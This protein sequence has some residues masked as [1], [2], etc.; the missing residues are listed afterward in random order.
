MSASALDAAGSAPVA[1]A[2]AAEEKSRA[3]AAMEA[4]YGAAPGKEAA[5]DG[6]EFYEDDEDDEEDDDEPWTLFSDFIDENGAAGVRRPANGGAAG[7]GVLGKAGAA[8]LG[9]LGGGGG[10]GGAAAKEFGASASRVQVGDF[11]S[12]NVGSAVST[13]ARESEKK[14]DKDRVR[15][16]DKADRATSEQVLD[17]RTRQM[18]DK[19]V[20]NG[21]LRA[22]HG[23]ISTGKE[24][25]V[26]YAESAEGDRA[27]K[28]Y[29]TSILVFKDRDKYVTGEYR[30]RH[31]YCKSNPR[32]MVK[33]WAEKE[34][35]NL[36]RLY[37]EGLPC[38]LPVALKNHVLIMSFIG[39]AEG[40]AAPRL[41]NAELNARQ[42]RDAYAQ[43]VRLMRRM[44][45]RCRLVHADLSEYN[46]LY[47]DGL[48]YVIDVSQSVEHDHPHA[49]DFLKKDAENMTRFFATAGGHSSAVAT[50]SVQE[51]FEFVTRDDLADDDATIDAYLADMARKVEARARSGAAEPTAA[52]QV[53]AAV[54]LGAPVLRRLDEIDDYEKEFAL[55]KKAGAVESFRA[56]AIHNLAIHGSANQTKQQQQV[57]KEEAKAAAPVPKPAKA[58]AP[59]VAAKATAAA[60]AAPAAAPAASKA[61][62]AHAHAAKPSAKAVVAP[63]TLAAARDQDLFAGLLLPQA[64]DQDTLTNAAS[65]LPEPGY[66]SDGAEDEDEEDEDDEEEDDLPANA[67]HTLAK[68]RRVMT[69]VTFGDDDEDDSDEDDDDD[70]EDDDEDDESDSGD[71]G[72]SDHEDG[73]GAAHGPGTPGW[74]ERPV[75][76]AEQL[77]AERKAQKK[78]A[79]EAQA[80][81]RKT[82]M[83]KKDKKKKLKSKK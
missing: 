9:G 7:P 6:E 29:K 46:L 75:L 73:E 59:A 21:T 54:F 81:K 63:P 42:M 76:T 38:P 61:H 23:C 15:H 40:Q 49:M 41:K 79:K 69:H 83:K 19:L 52:E 3:Q 57:P 30:F 80:E 62:A 24:A 34:M 16:K 31:G 13:S 37:S 67:N 45:H 68:S 36:K 51:L 64:G 25:N 65:T 11:S 2:P 66:V 12:R 47:F 39:S 72:K 18:L 70:D 10:G 82:K 35:R 71:E 22:I 77:R 60:A 14:L 33:V 26:Y 44:Y 50:M 27:V 5:A 58:V 28:I 1:A 55:Q 4:T 20:S 78:Q 48:V 74:V 32:K 56:D 17:P 43:V 8:G 53:A